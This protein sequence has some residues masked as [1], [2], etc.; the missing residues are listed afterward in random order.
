LAMNS[1][2]DML[3]A[4][5]IVGPS[6]MPH[7]RQSA[8]QLLLLGSLGVD[9]ERKYLYIDRS[10]GSAA[11]G[12]GANAAQAGALRRF[13]SLSVLVATVRTSVRESSH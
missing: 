8:S 2:L 12:T 11:F 6:R 4:A 7:Q 5:F 1:I 10:T 13:S 3:W 9:D